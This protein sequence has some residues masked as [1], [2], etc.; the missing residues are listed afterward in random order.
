MYIYYKVLFTHK[1]RHAY[2]YGVLN[3]FKYIEYIVLQKK[4]YANYAKIGDILITTYFITYTS[5]QLYVIF[6]SFN[7]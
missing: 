7:I 5:F 1:D 6:E 3:L 2:I 4:K